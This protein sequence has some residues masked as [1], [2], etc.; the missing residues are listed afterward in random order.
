MSEVGQRTVP[1]ILD[2]QLV[3]LQASFV[4]QFGNQRHVEIVRMAAQLARAERLLKQKRAAA[5]AI[6][7]YEQRVQKLKGDVVYLLKSAND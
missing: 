6:P 7:K 1:E 4:P 5:A 2:E 3:K